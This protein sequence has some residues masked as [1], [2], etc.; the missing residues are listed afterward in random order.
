MQVEGRLG[1][2]RAQVLVPATTNKASGTP[3]RA[4]GVGASAVIEFRIYGPSK[5]LRKMPESMEQ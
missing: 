4:K 5:A 3:G 1:S 2:G